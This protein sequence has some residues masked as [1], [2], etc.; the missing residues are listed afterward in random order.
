MTQCTAIAEST[1]SR[2]KLHAV[3]GTSRC[4]LHQAQLQV[5][6]KKVP[7]LPK[8]SK[9]ELA[10]QILSGARANQNIIEPCLELAMK[11]QKQNW[12]KE[13]MRRELS[14]RE[15]QCV[16]LARKVLNPKQ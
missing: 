16:S 5:S 2:C 9:K 13:R 3:H 4:H 11:V 10:Q 14:S 7:F 6:L 15:H 1:R 12:D 8:K